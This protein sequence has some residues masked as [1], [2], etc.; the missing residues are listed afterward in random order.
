MKVFRLIRCGLLAA[1]LPLVACD[2]QQPAEPPPEVTS[3]G[4]PSMEGTGPDAP[5]AKVDGVSVSLPGV[6]VGG[7]ADDESKMRQC[8]TASWLG[9]DPVPEG[10]SVV[11]TG[12]RIVPG[13]VFDIAGSSCGGIAGCAE[14]FAFTADGESCSVPVEA[15][16]AVEQPADLFMSGQARCAG[17]DAQRCNDLPANVPEKSIDL[18]QPRGDET[19]EETAEET[20]EEITEESSPEETDATG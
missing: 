13:G 17:R 1:A 8:V 2:A 10:V 5:G 6:P 16:A 11:V 19:N 18:T 12:I 9:G 7:D 20:T 15:R 14:S 3:T 4:S